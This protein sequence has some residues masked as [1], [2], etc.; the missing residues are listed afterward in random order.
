MSVPAPSCRCSGILDETQHHPAPSDR[1]TTMT[2]TR[3]M[4][5]EA[6]YVR[7]IDD[8]AKKWAD[9]YGAGPF[10]MVRHHETE[11]FS[12]R[13]RNVEA[14]VSYAFGYLGD[15]MIQF[16]EQHDDCLLYTSPSPRDS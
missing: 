5:Q 2:A 11:Q 16:I 6:Y 3:R 1:M 8:A 15:T 12:Y 9:A 14:D 13:G 4:F 7:S 10:Y